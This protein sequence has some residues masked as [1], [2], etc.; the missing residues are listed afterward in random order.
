MTLVRRSEVS[1]PMFFISNMCFLYSLDVHDCWGRIWEYEPL[2]SCIPSSCS[3]YSVCIYI[4]IC[5]WYFII[6]YHIMRF[7]GEGFTATGSMLYLSFKHP[8]GH[9]KV[10]YFECEWSPSN[11]ATVRSAS[12]APRANTFTR[13]THPRI[14]SPRCVSEGRVGAKWVSSDM[15]Q[16]QIGKAAVIQI[17]AITNI[18]WY[19]SKMPNMEAVYNGDPND[20]QKKRS[21]TIQK[22][23]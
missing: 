4:Y 1:Y 10:C 8:I 18:T 2:I 15:S 22:N 16:W 13:T 17:L 21:K 5:M 19:H 11:T 3:I 20:P 23:W 12:K 14:K 7:F 6:I 9:R